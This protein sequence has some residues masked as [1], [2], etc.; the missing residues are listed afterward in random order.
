MSFARRGVAVA[1]AVLFGGGVAAPAQA[2][3]GGTDAPASGY[4]WLAAV[5]SPA[6]LV[7]PQGQFCGGVLIAPDRVLTAAHCAAP[8]LPLPKALTVTFGRSDMSDSGGTTV[9]VS[10][11]R[12]HPGFRVSLFDGDLTYHDDVA[13]LTL[14]RP[15]ALPTVEIAAP[16]GD[17]G[18]V[19]GW[20]AT[21][22]ADESNTRLHSATVPLVGDAAC[23]TAY[24][25]EFDPGE[26]FCAGSATADTGQYDSGG[27]LLVD[28]KV[29]G[30][31]SWGKGAAQPGYPG[32]YARIPAL[33]F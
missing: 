4:P 25:A 21:S 27:P 13:V 5:G 32:V 12:V 18:T 16:H 3:V 23:A 2:V 7:R 22:D 19:V 6:F 14:D 11:I 1:A 30:I 9:G 10:A 15:M 26:A 8:G 31:T 28:G 17:S 29:A 20:G 33:N 24:G